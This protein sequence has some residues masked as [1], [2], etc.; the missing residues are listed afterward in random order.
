MKDFGK[1][2]IPNSCLEAEAECHV[3]FAF[4]GERDWHLENRKTQYNHFAAKNNIIMVYPKTY[5]AWDNDGDID[6]DNYMTRDGLYPKIIM[7]MLERLGEGCPTEEEEE[8]D[9]EDG[10]E[11]G[12]EQEESDDCLDDDQK[13]ALRFGLTSY[14]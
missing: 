2:Y 4:H 1:I 6:E 10:G 8:E 13:E 9:D 3:H 14:G 5:A 7:G 11:E 12:G